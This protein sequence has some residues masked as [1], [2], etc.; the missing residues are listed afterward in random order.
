MIGFEQ[1]K[2]QQQEVQIIKKE[3]IKTEQVE[4]QKPQLEIVAGEI[5]ELIGFEQPKIQKQQVQIIKKETKT[6]QVEIQRPQLEIA[7]GEEIELMALE[8]QLE[9]IPGEEV[10]LIQL[11]QPK[12]QVLKKEIIESPISQP[13]E[14]EIIKQEEIQTVK[15]TY[16][17]WTDELKLIKTTKLIIPGEK[18]VEKIVKEIE[19][20]DYDIE[21]YALNYVS[22]QKIR[23]SLHVENSKFDIEGNKNIIIK[24]G[25]AQ[26][27]K[28]TKEEIV[29]EKP[30][31]QILTE[32]RIS[33]FYLMSQPKKTEEVKK[34]TI[35][36]TESKT[37]ES[38]KPKIILKSAKEKQL[39]IKGIKPKQIQVQQIQQVES[40][41]KIN[42]NDVITLRKESNFNFIHQRKKVE[43]VKQVEPLKQI[44]TKEIIKTVQQI[45]DWNKVNKIENKGRFIL[46]GVKEKNKGEK[47]IEKSVEKIVEQKIDWN[48]A[49]KIENKGRFNLLRTKKEKE[50]GEKIV[51]KIVEKVIEQKIDWNKV[52]KMENKGRFN[53]L[54][55]ISRKKVLS[56]QNTNSINLVGMTV[57]K[58]A[59]MMTQKVVE[60][61]VKKDWK[62]TLQAQRNA[63]FTLS[64]KQ[65]IKK[66]KLL[67]ANGDKFFIQKESDDEIIYNDDYNTRKDTYKFRKQN[68]DQGEKNKKI[69]REKE[70]IKEKEYI[71]RLQREIRAQISKLK[72]SESET[73][74]SIS[75]IDV[76]GGIKSKKKL[77]KISKG[78]LNTESTL[79]GYKKGGDINGYQTKII[80][81]EVVFTAKNG[82]GV[83]LGGTQYQKQVNTKVGYTKKFSNVS[84]HNKMSGIDIINPKVKN[85]VFYQKMMG[86]SGAI[87]DGNYKI[88]GSKEINEKGLSGSISY[89]QMKV[90]S[91]I[92][93]TNN[94]N[95]N[96]S[97]QA[98]LGSNGQV[99][100]Y[101]KQIIITSN[102][103][104][105]IQNE[106]NGN[107]NSNVILNN[108][109]TKDSRKSGNSSNLKQKDSLNSG[110]N[111]AKIKDSPNSANIN[112]DINNQ[113]NTGRVVFN[114]RLRTDNSQNSS[115]QGQNPVTT[116]REYEMRVKTSRDGN[117]RVI[118]ESKKITEVK[119][120]K[121]NKTKNVEPL[122]DYDSQNSF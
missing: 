102:T 85:E 65:R 39:F 10:E 78:T 4:I 28:I 43:Q 99:Q 88:V 11:E 56:K 51:E 69:I 98:D 117:S 44:E 34:E 115:V 108:V 74:S 49:N 3:E 29:K 64:G 120:K 35:E 27:I 121:N 68:E 45:I 112:Y 40:I 6:E 2:I 114:S 15:T 66:Y 46:K 95:I 80:S 7:T 94:T 77:V 16:K 75:E 31:E 82:L 100:S 38:I 55:K 96:N 21:K 54:K 89:K 79:L 72:E 23:E 87:A 17:N 110:K 107:P 92:N 103:E 59:Q 104:N 67:V 116:K 113:L 101:R 20:E 109:R 36:I 52:N 105:N 83:N 84:S 42:W 47:I 61:I 48:K 122:R 58:N 73:S 86:T 9:V 41:K 8:Q 118:T 19:K 12:L 76:L 106:L 62:N 13:Q 37:V 93:N 90:I 81:G 32:A 1:P 5:I 63:K 50:K 18:K 111:N 25:P 91:N 71:P 26:N 119:F 22:D 33:Q 53:L 30:K 57:V 24:E 14:Q 70:I 60:K 97:S